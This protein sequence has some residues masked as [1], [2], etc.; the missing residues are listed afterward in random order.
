MIVGIWGKNFEPWRTKTSSRWEDGSLSASRRVAFL[1]VEVIE[2]PNSLES[3][4]ITRRVTRKL[5]I[6]GG[7]DKN[8]DLTQVTPDIV[9]VIT[10][11]ITAKLRGRTVNLLISRCVVRCVLQTTKTARSRRK[12]WHDQCD[13]IKPLSRGLITSSLIRSNSYA[14]Y[15]A[16]RF[17]RLCH[18]WFIYAIPRYVSS[19]SVHNKSM[20]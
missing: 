8:S 9:D 17:H 4:F 6:R 12:H 19:S 15:V 11:D 14:L 7:A 13:L 16:K 5:L 18:A 3:S 1:S 2:A 20:F 10:F